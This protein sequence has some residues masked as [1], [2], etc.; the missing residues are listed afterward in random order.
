MYQYE[1]TQY[2][3]QTGEGGLFVEYINTF[4]KLKAEASGYPSWVRCPEDEDRY[5]QSFYESEGIRLDKDAICMNAAKRA[6]AKLCL[7]SFWGKLTER[8]NRTESRMVSDP[9]ELYR[10]LA[11]PGIEVTNLMFASDE[12]VWL[13]WRYSDEEKIPNLKH[14]NEVLGAYVTA[15]ARLRLYHLLDRV[16]ENALYCDTDSIIFVQRENRAPMIECGDNLGDMQSEL[17][18]GEYIRE[19]VSGGPKNY[20]YRVV[21]AEGVVKTVCKVR[22]IRLNYNPSKLVNFDVIRKMVLKGGPRDVVT[23]HTNKKIKRKRKG[24]RVNIVTEPEDK[25]Y[26]VSFFNPSATELI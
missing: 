26:R 2:D 5:I 3:R 8:N 20:A 25:I 1:V 22:G 15:S 18:P 14:T 7:N 6:L 17:K 24:G 23:V 21:N 12:V 19:F 11:T 13:S 9:N 10:F 16:G 4:L